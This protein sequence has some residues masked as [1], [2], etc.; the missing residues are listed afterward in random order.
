MNHSIFMGRI[1]IVCR[2]GKLARTLKL[3]PLLTILYENEGRLYTLRHFVG[4]KHSLNH[5]TSH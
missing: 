3:N 5:K 1:F 4:T 2:F